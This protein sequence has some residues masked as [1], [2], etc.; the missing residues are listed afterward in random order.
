MKT[1]NAPVT[2]P[3]LGETHLPHLASRGIRVPR[4]RRA[5]LETGIVHFG[6]GAFHRV[7]QACYVDELLEY[8]PRW[9]LCEVALQS[10]T[11]RDAL[12]PQDW[13]Y[14]VATL[15]G[16]PHWQVVGAIREMLH[17]PSNP[18]Q[19]IQQLG[20]ARTH[21]VTATITEK[22]YCLRPDGGL[23]DTHP[24]IIH[25]LRHRDQ[26][27][28]LIGYLARALRL[29]HDTHGKPLSIISCDN[30]ADN[31]HRLQRAVLEFIANDDATLA[32]WVQDTTVF[33]CTM[34]DSIAPA[35]DP[36]LREQAAQVLGVHDGW[37]VQREAFSQWVIERNDAPVQ[38][39]WSSVGVTL[40]SDVAG[41]EHA[42]LRLLNAAHSALAYV[43]SL[44]G[45][46]T[47]TQAMR[48][49]T[50]AGYIRQLM[51]QDIRPGLK[52]PAGLNLPAYI[53][54]ILRRFSNPAIAHRLG[55][56]AWDGSQKLPIRLLPTLRQNIATGSNIDR[57]CLTLAAWM[58]FLRRRASE[59]APITD[60]LADTLAALAR[61]CTSDARHDVALFMG[62]QAVFGDELPRHTMLRSTLQAAYAHLTQVNDASSLAQA[63]RRF[64]YL[65]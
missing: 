42:K 3:P 18:A 45:Y 25:D 47:V 50:L 56:I 62:V 32:S 31:G 35:T 37:P 51:Y 36:S 48:D 54:D 28:T 2:L 38:P 33:P 63:L 53:S 58:H 44:A 16:E 55:Q 59:N 1:D 21:I 19:V 11:T 43:G 22:G 26:P 52:A 57:L 5:A 6:P 8:D 61:N 12:A 17:A 29:R 4:Y 40:T 14:S 27:R 23:D 64:G 15:A 39:D 65:S 20:D 34:V 10:T 13:L 49:E 7:H 30:L 41:F 60:P 9:G 24:D 46:D